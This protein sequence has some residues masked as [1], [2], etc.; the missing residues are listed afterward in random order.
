MRLASVIGRNFLYRVLQAI[1]E[2]GQRLDDDLAE[3]QASELIHEKQHLPELEYMFKHA[4]AQEATYESILLAR[5]RELHVRV[6]Q[7]I[8]A[9]FAGRLEAFYGLLAYHYAQA[10]AWDKAQ[11]YLLKA[12]DQA[13]QMAADAEALNL[14]EQAIAAYGRAFG[15][16][17][18]PAQRASLERKMGEAFRRRGDYQQAVEHFRHALGYLGYRLPMSRTEVR[19]ALVRELIVQVGHRIWPKKFVRPAVS[20]M[21]LLLRMKAGF[22]FAWH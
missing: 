21:P 18:D 17:W 22:I 16:Q 20:P 9:L 8:E 11:A 2:A 7:A 13:G 3:L 15:D 5:R 10:E 4:L 6:A 1:A 19:V 14:Y 12:A